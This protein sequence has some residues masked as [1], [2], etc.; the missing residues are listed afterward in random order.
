MLA[1][2]V[3]PGD[4]DQI[5]KWYMARGQTL[6]PK[7]LFPQI[8]IIVDDIAAGF[9]VR[10]DTSAAIIDGYISNPETDAKMRSDALDDITKSLME[11]AKFSGVRHLKFDSKSEAIKKRA[12][13][14]GFSSGGVHEVF[15]L[16]I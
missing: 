10:T 6:P 4:F 16:E 13:S 3:L 9:L 14:H 1:R 11:C 2:Y 15:T 7:S 8:G 5:C 12:L